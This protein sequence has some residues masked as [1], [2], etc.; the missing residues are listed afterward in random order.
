MKKVFLV[1]FISL[2][3]FVALYAQEL[4]S[5]IIINNTG[6]SISE[7]SIT[8]ARSDYYKFS[9][10]NDDYYFDQA[11]Y[12]KANDVC[13]ITYKFP[14]NRALNNGQTFSIKLRKSINETSLYDIQLKDTAGNNYKKSTV[15]ISANK[16]IEFTF[17]DKETPVTPRSSGDLLDILDA[18]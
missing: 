11:A 7:I 17:N 5:I 18:L 8:L 12:D 3:G 14:N 1:L 10:I 9:K 15:K 2:I 16:R 4:P 13:N 6:V